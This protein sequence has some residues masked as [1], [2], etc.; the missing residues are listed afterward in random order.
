MTTISKVRQII[1][2]ERLRQ[3]F[4]YREDGNLIYKI[5]TAQSTYPG[6]VAGSTNKKGV[7][8]LSMDGAICF[9]SRAIWLWHHGDWPVNLIDHIDGNTQNNRIE[10][11]RDVT[12]AVN[13][14]NK[15]HRAS[16]AQS[17]FTGVVKMRKSWQ[18]TIQAAGRRIH[19][20]CFLTKEEAFASY[21]TAKKILHD[22]YISEEHMAER[23]EAYKP[24]R[25]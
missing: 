3:V 24:V 9:M 19:L 6:K 8:L 23:M 21:V 20:G 15:R 17:N 12:H 10:N 2:C 18:A 22:G 13:S 4:D 25:D 1:S 11:L 14:Y 16:R 7:V 5:R